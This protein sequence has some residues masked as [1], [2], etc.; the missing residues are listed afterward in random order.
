M[1]DTLLA[2]R[3]GSGENAKTLGAARV[4]R[5]MAALRRVWRWGTVK[6]FVLPSAP[7]PAEVMLSETPAKEILATEPEVAA[8]FTA[9]DD[10]SETLGTLVRFLVGT[11]ARLPDALAIRWRDVNQANGD[12]ATRGQKTMRPLRV[13]MLAPAREAITRSHQVCCE[14]QARLRACA[15]AVQGSNR[16]GS[17]RSVRST[18][19]V[20][21]GTNDSTATEASRS[22]ST[23]SAG[24]PA[25]RL[26]SQD[27]GSANDG[28]VRAAP[29][30]TRTAS[31]G[32]G[33]CRYVPAAARRIPRRFT[34]RHRAVPGSRAGSSHRVADITFRAGRVR[35][36][37][38][39]ALRA[40]ARVDSAVS[41]GDTRLAWRVTCDWRRRRECG[42]RNL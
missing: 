14:G 4:N 38:E 1:R 23:R 15:L 3:L 39:V 18:R 6:G 7:W 31:P 32:R 28:T 40:A 22:R 9:C 33:C 12:V 27:V 8:I 11:G 26:T 41:T 19:A 29:R 5:H 36:K 2:R 24:R 35:R 13:A 34:A 42:Q 20:A 30:S 17:A 21:F 25:S 10:I 16:I 37:F